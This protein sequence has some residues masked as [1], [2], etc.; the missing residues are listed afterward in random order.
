MVLKSLA[1]ARGFV[2]TIF[3]LFARDFAPGE[4]WNNRKRVV[5]KRQG[6]E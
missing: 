5:L 6:G 2:E 1:E 3:H 4:T